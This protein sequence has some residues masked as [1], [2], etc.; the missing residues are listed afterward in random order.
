LTNTTFSARSNASFTREIFANSGSVAVGQFAAMGFGIADTILLGRASS[1]ELAAFALSISVSI[2][3]MVTLFGVMSALAPLMARHYGAGDSHAVGRMT[4]QGVYVALACSLLASSILLFPG[5]LLRLA[6]VPAELHEKVRGYLFY[7][8]LST[9]FTL[10][11]R[12]YSNLNIAISR[13]GMVTFIQIAVLPVKVALSYWFIFGGWGLAAMGSPGAGLATAI[14]L[15]GMF[16]VACALLLRDA[17]YARFEI[18]KAW[19]PPR[20]SEI[21]AILALGIPSGASY[22][23]EVTAFA[24]MA[25]FIARTGTDALAAHQIVGNF[26]SAVYM[27]PLSMAMATSALCAQCLGAGER[28]AARRVAYLGMR[29][30]LIVTATLGLIC[31]AL[32]GSIAGIYTLSPA[33]QQIASTLFIFIAAYQMVDGLQVMASFLLRAYKVAVLPLVAYGVSLWGIGL[34]GGYLVA[35]NVFGNSPTWALGAAGMWLGNAVALTLL[36]VA[37]VWM[38][39][40]VAKRA[41]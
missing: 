29:I 21:K 39:R 18:F 1:S 35:F 34:G 5:W 2:S 41:V 11:F 17:S 7:L 31:F 4:Q 3:I 32:R 23:I 40:R 8:A 13:P 12:V 37:L 16:L 9:P 28:E 20:W 26:A 6:E 36:C 25:I 19:Q 30:T 38:L 10:L 15:F 27:L 14:C 22:C 24:L 33:V